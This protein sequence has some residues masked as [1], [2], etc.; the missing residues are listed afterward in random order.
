MES[1][2]RIHSRESDVGSA[3][4]DRSFH[5]AA[6]GAFKHIL[7]AFPPQNGKGIL[8]AVFTTSSPLSTVLT[9]AGFQILLLAAGLTSLALV[10]LTVQRLNSSQL[11][12][13]LRFVPTELRSGATPSGTPSSSD[14]RIL[15]FKEGCPVPVKPSALKFEGADAIAE[16]DRE[17]PFVGFYFSTHNASATFDPVKFVVRA[18]REGEEEWKDVSYS[19]WRLGSNG[20]LA[21]RRGVK[22]DTPTA[23]GQMVRVEKRKQR[24]LW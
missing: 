23:R 12:S 18:Q 1:L 17:L 4:E 20:E 10:S 24:M 3:A 6:R 7:A 2:K 5:A 8:S 14:F 13:A 15:A 16:Y 11:A 9:K 21:R 19:G 22:F